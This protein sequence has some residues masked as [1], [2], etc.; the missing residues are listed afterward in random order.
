[1]GMSY[2]SYRTS[3][4]QYH[5]IFFL[6]KDFCFSGVSVVFAATEMEP[7]SFVNLLYTTAVYALL[8][9]SENPW[10]SM[11]SASLATKPVNCN[12]WRMS[13]SALHF[14]QLSARLDR[15]GSSQSKFKSQSIWKRIGNWIINQEIQ[16]SSRCRT[17]LVSL[18]SRGTLECLSQDASIVQ[19]L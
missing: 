13:R 11:L 16:I 4:L 18:C 14:G 8:E 9:A 6:V 2:S 15:R 5:L 1:M 17:R 7:S 10:T 12:F 3:A 19:E